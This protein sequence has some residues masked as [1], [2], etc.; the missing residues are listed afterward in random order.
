MWALTGPTFDLATFI[1]SCRHH[2]P[3]RALHYK[4]MSSAADIN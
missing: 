1:P 3:I 2:P 4:S